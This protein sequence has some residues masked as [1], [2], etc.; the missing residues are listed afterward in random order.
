MSLIRIPSKLLVLS[1]SACVLAACGG[2]GG[3]SAPAPAPVAPAPPPP[4]PPPPTSSSVTLSGKATYDRVP[5]GTNGNGLNF[6]AITQEPI[7]QAVIELLDSSDTVL[8]SG[9]TD[10]NGDYSFTVDSNTDVKVRVKAQLLQTTGSER[11]T[12]ILDNTNSNALYALEGSLSSSGTADQ[13]R[14]LNADSGWTGSSYTQP[15]AAAPFALLDTMLKVK[16]VFVSVDADV[17]FPQLN[18]FWSVDNRPVDGTVANGEIG[19]SSYTIINNVPTILILGDAAADTD[20]F[21]ESVVAHEFGHF[22]ENQIGRTDTLGGQHSLTARLDKRLAFSEGWANALSGFSVAQVYRDS[23][24]NST[25]DFGFD[26]ETNDYGARGWFIEGSVQSIL[27]DVMDGASDGADTISA[28]M[29]PIYRT[30]VSQAFKDIAPAVSIFS[31]SNFLRTETGV[32]TAVYD[33]LLSNQNINSSE[34]DG[35]GETNDGGLPGILPVYRTLT[36]GAAAVPFCSIDDAGEYNRLGNRTLFLM[37][38]PTTQSVTLTMTAT[39]NP[40]DTDPDFYIYDQGNLI[41]R[42]QSADLNTET[43]TGSFTAG[44]YLIDAYDFV[45]AETGGDSRDSCFTMEAQ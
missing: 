1:A 38:V 36:I 13:V 22:F 16:D 41:A 28:G 19:T 25:Q 33:Q 45:N 6:S 7:R 18:V 35:A 15:R 17:D 21:D 24:N 8:Q 23:F 10:D 29:G 5:F 3:S 39:S 4:P 2:G 14:N 11:N 32:D 34:L 27:Y 44:T 43:F 20:E 40:P 12:R 30:F 9:V 31:F 26:L 37:D 42:A